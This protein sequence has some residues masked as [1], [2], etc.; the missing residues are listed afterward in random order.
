[1]GCIIM[2]KADLIVGSLLAI[3]G[4]LFL[5]YFIPNQTTEA[6]E[7]GLSP[8]FFPTVLMIIITVMAVLLLAMRLWRH[9]DSE[10]QKAPLDKQNLFFIHGVCGFLF[11]SL[12]V[13]NYI[14]YIA[15]GIVVVSGAMFYLGAK[16]P[17]KIMLI[18]ITGPVVF[19]YS[20]RHF[21]N[22]IL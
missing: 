3:T 14:G 16:S 21:L 10:I 13:M 5:F 18:S 9:E 1:M 15:G 22:V 8:S 7:Y 4:L 2:K 12:A 11:F 19:Y 17:I 6:E 20:I